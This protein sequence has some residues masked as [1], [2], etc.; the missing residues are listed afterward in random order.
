[1]SFLVSKMDSGPGFAVLKFHTSLRSPSASRDR[2]DAD[3]GQTYTLWKD[4]SDRASAARS[5]N[6]PYRAC[7][8]CLPAHRPLFYHHFPRVHDHVPGIGG[9]TDDLIHL[10]SGR[11]K[12][13]V[14]VEQTRE[15]GH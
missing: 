12:D 7:L 8:T 15:L 4:G 3:E 11:K 1:M 9:C 14:Y 2:D 6:E 10:P 13:Q 5:A